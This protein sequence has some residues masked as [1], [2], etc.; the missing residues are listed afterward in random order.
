MNA[1]PS[2][3][4][5]RFGQGRFEGRVTTISPGGSLPYDASAWAD[6]I[7][8]V[9][10]GQIELEGVR[11]LRQV[12]PAGATLWLAGLALRAIH[13]PG[14]APVALMSVCRTRHHRAGEPQRGR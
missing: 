12:I 4:P 10:G 3:G 2:C 13:N 14:P 5:L 9:H 7:V 1:P 11:G 6:A 8:T